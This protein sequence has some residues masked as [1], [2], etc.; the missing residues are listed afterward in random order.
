MIARAASGPPSSERAP[1]TAL[2]PAL[3]RS[4]GS[5]VPINPVEQTATSPA[6]TSSPPTESAA[7]TSSAVRCVSPNP[8]GPVHALAPPELSTTA[9]RRPSATACC[10]QSTGAALTRFV[11]NTAAATWS[12]PVL[13]TSAR[14]GRPLGFRPAVTPPARKPAAPVTLTGRS[15]CTSARGRGSRGHS[16]QRQTGG[17]GQPEGEVHALHRSAG[18]ALG[19][20][21]ESGDGDQPARRAVDRHLDLDDVRAEH[22]LR[23]GPGAG[24][25]ELDERLV[26]Q[27]LRVH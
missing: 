9:C 18:C 27:S 1:A 17:L 23:L 10:D 24:R 26:R 13:T 22:G 15:W 5:R 16:Y 3:I 14:S 11:V 6:P 21:V 7:A 12:G 19:Q 25:Q 2:P 4:I 20:V 8:A